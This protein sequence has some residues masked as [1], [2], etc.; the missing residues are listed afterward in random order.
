MGSIQEILQSK[1]KPKEKQAKLTEAVCSGLRNVY[2]KAL[3]SMG[4]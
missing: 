3:K 4:K 1:L 2:L